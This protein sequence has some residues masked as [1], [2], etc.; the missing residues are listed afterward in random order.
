MPFTISN[1]FKMSSILPTLPA[2]MYN[3]TGSNGLPAGVLIPSNTWYKIPNSEFSAGISAA[4]TSTYPGRPLIA[5]TFAR[6]IDQYGGA[7]FRNN[8][9]NITAWGGGHLGGWINGVGT[10]GLETSNPAWQMPMPPS[11]PSSFGSSAYINQAQS[12]SSTYFSPYN[13]LTVSEGGTVAD[14]LAVCPNYPFTVKAGCSPAYSDASLNDGAPVPRQQGHLPCFIDRPDIDAL[15]VGN[16]IPNSGGGNRPDTISQSNAWPWNSSQWKGPLVQG[17]FAPTSTTAGTNPIIGLVVDGWNNL[18]VADPI[19]GWIYQA[20]PNSGRGLTRWK[21]A[22]NWGGPGTIDVMSS[23][24]NFYTAIGGNGFYGGCVDSAR[25]RLIIFD[26]FQTDNLWS[27]DVSGATVPG[28]LPTLRAT[29]I[30]Q[31]QGAGVPHGGRTAVCVPA[32]TGLNTT[33]MNGAGDFYAV[34]GRLGITMINPNTWS[35]SII[36]IAG[37]GPE[38]AIPNGGGSWTRFGYAKNIKCFYYACANG[39]GTWSGGTVAQD[40]NVYVIRISA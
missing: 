40:Y 29:N 38:Y 15:I 4:Y 12:P 32:T 11:L 24:G 19:N 25:Q 8:G 23:S 9:S 22:T 6:M 2:W 37:T 35:T 39:G 13:M 26:G 31:A 20:S 36:P 3:P 30:T 18:A 17:G 10:Y 34:L 16:G 28:G 14:A 7:G 33:W 1:M 27:A 21:I 5:G